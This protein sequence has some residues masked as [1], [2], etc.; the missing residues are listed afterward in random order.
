MQKHLRVIL[1][2]VLIALGFWAW[3]ALF[4]SPEKVIQ[5]R[6]RKL[7]ATGSFE[8]GAGTIPKAYKAS[9]I[10]DYFTPDV[11]IHVN[12]PGYEPLSVDNREEVQQYVTAGFNQLRGLKLEFLDINVKLGPDKQTAVANLTGKATVNGERDFSVQEFNFMLRKVD[13][14]WLIYRVETVKTLSGLGRDCEA[15]AAAL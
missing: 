1:V 15:L 10:P 11:V 14:K 2:A 3:R 4:P 6:L 9:Q 12:A 13:G 5:S 8:V 7:A